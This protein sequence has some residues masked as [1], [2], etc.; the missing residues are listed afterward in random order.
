MAEMFDNGGPAKCQHSKCHA[1]AGWIVEADRY[2]RRAGHPSATAWVGRLVCEHHADVA[3]RMDERYG[4]GILVRPLGSL[5]A[6]G[7]LWP[8]QV[9]GD[10]A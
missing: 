2:S 1:Y 6:A 3:R 4:L 8:R 5:Q 9:T 10:Q 7:D